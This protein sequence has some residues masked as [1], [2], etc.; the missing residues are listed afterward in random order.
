MFRFDY[1][2]DLCLTL[3]VN[4]NQ[5]IFTYTA[6]DDF[7]DP[8]WITS[9][10]PKIYYV[11]Q[12]SNTLYMFGL[13]THQVIYSSDRLNIEDMNANWVTLTYSPTISVYE[14]RPY[15]NCSKMENPGKCIL[16]KK[17][18]QSAA[19]YRSFFDQ[20]LRLIR[21]HLLRICT[22]VMRAYFISVKKLWRNPRR[23]TTN[24]ARINVGTLF[25]LGCH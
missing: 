13:S 20:F 14:D 24:I 9:P 6:F 17:T 3:L 23:E 12:G 8:P 19:A 25:I 5:E 15:S 16:K 10:S 4:S 1:F 22:I 11:T 18:V 2:Y 21:Y 7:F